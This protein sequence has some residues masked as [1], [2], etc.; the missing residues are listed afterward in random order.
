MYVKAQAVGIGYGFQLLTTTSFRLHVKVQVV[1]IV[2]YMYM[3]KGNF[4]F[5]I[6]SRIQFLNN[7]IKGHGQEIAALPVTEKCK[8]N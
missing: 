8:S 5:C 7:L 6:H 1:G 4:I 2:I 3:Y